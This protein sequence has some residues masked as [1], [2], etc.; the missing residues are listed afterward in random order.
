MAEENVNGL[1]TC[2]IPVSS[3]LSPHSLFSVR[4][5]EQAHQHWRTYPER[6]RE[7][8]DMGSFL[9]SKGP[10]VLSPV[11]LVLGNRKTQDRWTLRSPGE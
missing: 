3:L 5:G 7:E 4:V 10:R 1:A 6:E 11:F 2:S 9:I 8:P